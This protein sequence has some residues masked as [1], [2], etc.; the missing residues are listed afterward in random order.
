MTPQAQYWR[1]QLMRAH[2]WGIAAELVVIGWLAASGDV[3]NIHKEVSPEG[4]NP[5]WDAVGY[6]IGFPIGHLCYQRYV[7]WVYDDR[8]KGEQLD[9]TVIP[10]RLLLRFITIKAVIV[11][12]VIWYAALG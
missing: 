10:R 5:L 6:L 4:A 3:I 12:A 7:R 11:Y 1:D 9:S 8:L 2:A